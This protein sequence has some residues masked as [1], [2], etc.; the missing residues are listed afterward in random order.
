MSEK[1]FMLAVHATPRSG[2]DEVVGVEAGAQGDE[3]RVR[4]TAPPDGGKAN[5]AVC[6]VLAQAL[7]VPKTSVMVVSG[8]T[9]RHKRVSIDDS[10]EV[11]SAWVLSL[12]R[13]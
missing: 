13:C 11:I 3:V 4:V 2:R 9:S 1:P 5:K 12:P 7:G 6:K 10:H 8:Q